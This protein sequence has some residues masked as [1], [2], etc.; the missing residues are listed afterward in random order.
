MLPILCTEQD[1][2]PGEIPG[3]NHTINCDIHIYKEFD[4]TL[5]EFLHYSATEV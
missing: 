2:Y 4:S 3:Y 5:S 1:L